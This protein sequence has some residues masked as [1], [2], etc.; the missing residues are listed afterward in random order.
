MARVLSN[1]IFGGFSSGLRRALFKKSAANRLALPAP[2]VFLLLACVSTNSDRVIQTEPGDWSF[3]F[4]DVRSTADPETLS[5]IQQTT[6]TPDGSQAALFFSADNHSSDIFLFAKK[7]VDGLLAGQA[8]EV[9]FQ[10]TLLSRAPAGLVGI[11]GSPGSSVFVKAG[12]SA[13]EPF[14]EVD[15]AG[16]LRMNI[17]IGSQSQAG[18]DALVLGDL[19]VKGLSEPR[20]AAKKLNGKTTISADPDGSF[21]VLVGIDCGFAGSVAVYFTQIDL[22]IRRKSADL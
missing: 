10:I 3:G 8:Y 21:W 22:D 7:K 20:F 18:K 4:A 6:A 2:V 9:G 1:V 19:V 14:A 16:W 17:D 15:D 11:G 13:D 12:G 5:I